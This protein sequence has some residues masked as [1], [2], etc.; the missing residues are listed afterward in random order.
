MIIFK[1]GV[2]FTDAKREILLAISVA[3]G[4]YEKW[5][6]VLVVTS[7]CDGKHKKYSHHYKG[8]A[9]DIR[10]RYFKRKNSNRINIT[11]IRKVAR[12]LRMVLG[13]EYQVIIE[14]NHIHIEYDPMIPT[15]VGHI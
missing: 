3:E 7:I 12:E 15:S 5:N 10:T 13:S 4:V 9:F 8:L 14:S 11:I 6:K 2:S 1:N